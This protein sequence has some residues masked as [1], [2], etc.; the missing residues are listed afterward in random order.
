MN[1]ENCALKLVDEIILYYNA[2]SKKHQTY[3]IDWFRKDSIIS[4]VT[5]LPP[6]KY[7]VQ[8]QE[9]VT[10]LPIPQNPPN[11]LFCGYQALSSW[12]KL[13]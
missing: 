9:G 12:G 13:T 3:N 2:R 11:L 8:I 10:D 6:G 4:I 5:M 1:K 7:R